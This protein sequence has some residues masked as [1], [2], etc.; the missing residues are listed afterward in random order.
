MRPVLI[1]TPPDQNLHFNEVYHHNVKIQV[2][3]VLKLI[4]I[5]PILVVI[6]YQ[7]GEKNKGQTFVYPLSVCEILL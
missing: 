2:P 5:G 6:W 7:I 1:M 3:K 4:Q